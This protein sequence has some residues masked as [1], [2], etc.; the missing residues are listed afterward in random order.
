MLL[1]DAV[2]G[3]RVHYSFEFGKSVGEG[4]TRTLAP[5]SP[6][7]D[8]PL[9][10]SPRG[11]K[12]KEEKNSKNTANPCDARFLAPFEIDAISVLLRVRR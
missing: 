7:V 8:P 2:L 4:R 12:V 9:L 10:F 3:R 11:Q 6:V 5:S 1:H